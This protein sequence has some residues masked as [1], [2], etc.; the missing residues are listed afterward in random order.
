V[1]TRAEMP[2]VAVVGRPN[3]G[4][5]SLVNRILGRREA[6][7]QETPGVTR[8][9]RAF[10]AE[11]AGRSFELIDTGG[12]E[13][14]ATGMD[15]R[16]A[17]Q[18]LVAMELADVIVLVLDATMGVTADDLEVATR[19]RGSTKPVLVAVNK[20][21]D[22]TTRAQVAE[23][24]SLGL[25]DPH[26]VSALH[27]L[28]SG[29]LLDEI[30]KALPR[31][32]EGGTDTWAS[33]ALVGRPNVGKSS[34]LNA[35]LREE[36]SIVDSTPGTTR[37]PIDSFLALPGDRVLRIV[38]TAG[39]RREV[40][41]KDPIEYFSFLRSRGT[42]DKVD[43]ALLVID[44]DEGV[45]THDQKIANEIVDAGRA[46]VILLNKWDLVGSDDAD[47]DRFD[48]SI[49]EKLRF[50]P[51]A[52]VARTSAL[53]KRGMQRV[54]PAVDS[55][56]DSHRRRVPT[57]VINRLVRDAQIARP[58]PRTQGKAVRILYAVQA[59][60]SPPQIVL[61][62]SGRVERNY[63]RYLEHAIREHEEFAGSPVAFKVRVRSRDGSRK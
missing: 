47:R 22:P 53:T 13:P 33:V 25:G 44:A 4:K 58:H 61:F 46:C 57:A 2:V 3:V 23:F 49:K 31:L 29:D 5:S 8:D 21:D 40:Q 56:I 34:I 16:I 20:V 18:A 10:T 51:W 41:I 11:W 35:L 19:L 14:G 39:M 37:D 9:R 27:G 12:L 36:R 63:V 1:K 24:Y 45:T 32:G 54:L 7:V 55:A 28:G 42:L 43:A 48:R 60:V 6:I 17:E 50:V 62:S 15:A 30:G 38:D 52:T 59:A 26:P